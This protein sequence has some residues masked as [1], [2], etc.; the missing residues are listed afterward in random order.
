M[1]TG[2]IPL[3]RVLLLVALA[4]P[5]SYITHC[6]TAVA[7]DDAQSLLKEGLQQVRAGNTQEGIATLRKALAANPASAE[8]LAALGRAEWQAMMDLMVSGQEGSNVAKAILDLAQPILPDR[9]FSEAE[10][11]RLTKEAVTAEDYTDRFDAAMSLARTY[12]E[13]AVPGLLDYL[14]GSNTD[15]RANAHITL[16]SRI[17]RDAVLPLNEALRH[18]N[19]N[20]RRMAAA[21]LGVIGDERSLA[22]V[23]EAALSDADADA[24][25]KAQEALEKLSGKYSWAAGLS[26]A[27]LYLRLAELYYAGNYR[28]LANADRPIVVWSWQGSLMNTPTARHVY[29]LKLAEEAAY[30][31]LRLDP[32]SVGAR[33]LLARILASEKLAAGVG[34]DDDLSKNAAASLAGVGATLSAMGWE[35]LSTALGDSL[36][37]GDNAA[38]S[39]ILSAMPACYG[40]SDFGMDSP[41]VRALSASAGSVRLAATEAVLRFNGT[42]RIAAFPDPDGFTSQVAQAVGEVI[43]RNVLVVDGDDNRRNK[44]VGELNNAKYF[45]FDART[46]SDG[47]VRATRYAGLDLIVMSSNLVDMEALALIARLRD[48]DRTKSIPVVVVGTAE[49]AA[50]DNWRNLYKDNA[51]GLTSVPEGPGLPSEDF[52]KTVADSFSSPMPGVTDRYARSAAVLDALATTDTGNA[53]FN[54]GSLTETLVGLLGADLPDDPPVRLNAIRAM[55]NIGDAASLEP[56]ASFFA[57][58]GGADARAAT[59]AAIAAV[60]QRNPTTLPDDAFK[61]LLAGT[62][63]A[64]ASVRSAACSALG[65]SNLTPEQANAILLANR[66]GT[67]PTAAAGEEEG[68]GE[69]EGCAEE[70]TPEEEGCGCAEEGCGG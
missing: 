27:E 65:S 13:F 67:A 24:R 12:G 30:D 61:A 47:F 66:P 64:D 35:T 54:W 15:H 11:A 44:I 9:A 18:D 41:V 23:A 53:L 10:L 29:V 2:G 40:G 5:A 55:R 57:K 49:Q 52:L 51:K 45:V 31:S 70:E 17:G 19:A 36:D 21:E 1:A 8:V 34:G 14:A 22:A 56:L 16:M 32:G 68:G 37:E 6:S 59:A 48:N 39:V 20:V 3:A 69:E 33:A 60:C 4:I 46:G 25:A 28:V 63:D 7:Q 62:G 50:D 58:G 38:A 43:P 26:P 42:R